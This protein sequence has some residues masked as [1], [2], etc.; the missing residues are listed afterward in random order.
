M[1]HHYLIETKKRTVCQIVVW[2][3]A[4][5]LPAFSVDRNRFCPAKVNGQSLVTVTRLQLFLSL[6]VSLLH[7][8]VK[9]TRRD[10]R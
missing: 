1:N 10:R 9:H 5:T 8:Q 2:G 3:K 7:T 6:L 4:F